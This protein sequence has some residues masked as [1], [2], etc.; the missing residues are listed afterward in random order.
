MNPYDDT[1][2]DN[3]TAYDFDIVN[4]WFR[5]EGTQMDLLLVS[6]VEYDP[7]T[8]FIE[9]WGSSSGAAWQYFRWVVSPARRACTATRTATSCPSET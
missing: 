1:V 7:A 6:G 4:A 5:V 3:Q 9:A 8:V 2:G